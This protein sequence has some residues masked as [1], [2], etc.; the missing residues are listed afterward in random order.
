MGI[1][2]NVCDISPEHHRLTLCLFYISNKALLDS[3]IWFVMHFMSSIITVEE[4]AI[5]I[6]PD[7][8]FPVIKA[9]FLRSLAHC[10]GAFLYAS[11]SLANFRCTL[12]QQLPFSCES[13]CPHLMWHLSAELIS[14]HFLST[15]IRTLHS[16][17]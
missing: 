16:C 5:R 12:L 17:I 9:Q 4:K 1:Q 11:V 6:R 10:R 13:I 3:F 15:T 7:D 2:L 14:R 8:S